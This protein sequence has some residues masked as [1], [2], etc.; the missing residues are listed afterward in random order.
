MSC[1]IHSLIVFW[2]RALSYIITC[3]TIHQKSF[4][5]SLC[6]VLAKILMPAGSKDVPVGK[7][8]CVIVS[9]Y[10]LWRQSTSICRVS[11]IHGFLVW[12]HI[13]LQIQ[14][15]T[16]YY[17]IGRMF[18]NKFNFRGLLLHRFLYSLRYLAYEGLTP[19]EHM[20]SNAGRE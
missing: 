13:H 1:I 7:A 8:L 4:F 17:L 11:L 16:I 19:F 10:L 5:C 2:F 12:G 18:G 3:K 14:I 20:D 6:R 15:I 9:Y